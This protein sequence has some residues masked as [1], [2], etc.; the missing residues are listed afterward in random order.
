MHLITDLSE[1][2]SDMFFS[3]QMREMQGS[4]PVDQ[5]LGV[6]AYRG[7]ILLGINCLLLVGLFHHQAMIALGE[8]K[9]DNGDCRNDRENHSAV[10]HEVAPAMFMKKPAPK[11]P[12]VVPTAMP[13]SAQSHFLGS[14]HRTGTRQRVQTGITE[15]GMTPR[16]IAEAQDVPS[17]PVFDHARNAKTM[18]KTT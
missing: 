13:V 18:A 4:D 8:E 11:P 14:G 6:G 3:F 15:N 12:S 2:F 9:N 16:R 5:G 10:A 1:V 17:L 7:A